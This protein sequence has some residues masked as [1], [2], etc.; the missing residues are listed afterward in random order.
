ME[1]A[2]MQKKTC[3]YEEA[4]QHFLLILEVSNALLYATVRFHNNL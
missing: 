4:F 1:H 2:E 3:G